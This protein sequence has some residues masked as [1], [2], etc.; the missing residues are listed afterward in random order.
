MHDNPQLKMISIK[1]F[2][3]EFVAFMLTHRHDSKLGFLEYTYVAPEP[4]LEI[5]EEG[6]VDIYTKEAQ[7]SLLAFSA[8]STS[9]TLFTTPVLADDPDR[10]TSKTQEKHAIDNEKRIERSLANIMKLRATY[11]ALVP[12][13]KAKRVDKVKE[14]EK[15]KEAYPKEYE[16][17]MCVLKQPGYFVR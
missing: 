9:L 2:E 14:L 11:L 16:F 10:K 5:P 12:Y 8:A 17:Y 1:D 4:V 3:Y 6:E 13:F 15:I 7:D